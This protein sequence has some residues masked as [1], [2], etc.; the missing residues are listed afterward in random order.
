[1]CGLETS[2]YTRIKISR[3]YPRLADHQEDCTSYTFG[4]LVNQLHSFS[5]EGAKL[6]FFFLAFIF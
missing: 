4:G 6:G 5:P 1:M 3:L 2:Q